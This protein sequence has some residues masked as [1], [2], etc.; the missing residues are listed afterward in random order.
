MV[1]LQC[2]G[3]SQNGH[4]SMSIHCFRRCASRSTL[5][6]A[7]PELVPPE[8]LDLVRAKTLN[9]YV[10]SAPSPQNA[11]D[12]FAG[13]WTS[14]FPPPF[15]TLTSGQ[16][17]LFEDPRATH[18]IAVLGGVRGRRVLELGPL[19]GGHTYLLDRAGASEI[20]SIEGNT[21]AYLKCLVT[22]EVVG[23]PSARF[24]RGDFTEYLRGLRGTSQR[25]DLVFASGVLYHMVNPVELIADLARVSDRVFMWTHYYD[26]DLLAANERNLY[27]I[28]P[29]TEAVHAGFH[30]TLYRN[31]YGHALDSAA[32]CGGNVLF[33]GRG[34]IW[35]RCATLV[36][37]I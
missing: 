35:A 21:R 2:L 16:A 31:D 13:E 27:R 10:R 23:I 8:T 29:P 37:R 33:S 24:L 18:G 4:H 17:L 9:G 15:D 25:F 7:D 19:E 20:I 12:I 11:L 3:L 28:V 36:S 34:T 26:K 5:E 14:R 32:F 1:I 22:K 6:R 30:H